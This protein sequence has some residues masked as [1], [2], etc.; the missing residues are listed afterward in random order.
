VVNSW[1]Q[2][3]SHTAWISKHALRTLIKRAYP[4][5]LK[6]MGF[7]RTPKLS[8]INLA[9]GAKTLRLGHRLSMSLEITSQSSR[10]HPLL[11]D[12]V[13]HYVKASG[14]TAPKVFKWKE[15]TI[16][17]KSSLTLTKQQL[18]R[19]FSTRRHYPGEHRIDVQINGHTL[20]TNCFILK[21]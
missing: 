20:A 18:I 4:P 3:N 11:I 21:R 5:A 12:Y 8:A 13:V 16:G 15:V 19:D 14:A 7:G 17:P 6:F 2:Q 10:P 9:L 1:D